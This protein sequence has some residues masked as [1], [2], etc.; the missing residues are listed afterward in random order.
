MPMS[1][2]ASLLIRPGTL[3]QALRLVRDDGEPLRSCLAGFL[4]EFY[5][6]REAAGRR[7]RIEEA[8]DLTGDERQDAFMGGI[9]EHLCHRWEL[10]EPP[11]W[12]D[13]PKRFLSRPW[14]I[15]PERMKAFLL[16][17]SP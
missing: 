6:D 15:G 11:G 7:A 14:F 8:P 1:S 3:A 10:G 13:D 4:D 5:A 12:T 9:G 2:Q 16:A 17:E